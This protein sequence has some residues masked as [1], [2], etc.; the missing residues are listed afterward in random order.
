MRS[1]NA[2]RGILSGVAALTALSGFLADWNRTHLFNPRWPPHAKFHDAWTILLGAELGATSLWLL[3][4]RDPDVELAALLP[5]LFAAA[6]AGSYALPGAA[7]I[8]RE[9]PDPSVRPLAV[10]PPEWGVSA[11]A[12][13]LTGLGYALARRHARPDGDVLTP[14]RRAARVRV[15]PPTVRNRGQR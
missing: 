3:W 12:L 8:A 15:A 10:R 1:T 4:R 13:A 7:G 6:Q 14:A 11:A 5:A 9:F 2:G